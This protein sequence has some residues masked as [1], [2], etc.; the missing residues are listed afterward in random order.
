[1][2]KKS[3]TRDEIIHLA[4]LAGLSLTDSQIEK[5]KTQLEETI[6]YI[7]NLNELETKNVDPTSHTT[8]LTNVYFNDGEKNERALD[9]PAIFQN[10]KNKEKNYFKV[11]S[12]F[13]E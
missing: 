6:S 10:V 5:Y 4:K 3:L 1:M 12:I 11:S 8:S 9:L 7:E 2:K 13:D